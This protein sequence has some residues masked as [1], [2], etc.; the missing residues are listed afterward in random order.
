LTLQPHEGNRQRIDGQTEDTALV[1]MPSD[2]MRDDPHTATVAQMLEDVVVVTSSDTRLHH[3]L[4]PLLRPCQLP[5][6]SSSVMFAATPP[7]EKELWRDRDEKARAV[8]ELEELRQDDGLVTRLLDLSFL[9][10]FQEQIHDDMVGQR[11]VKV[12]MFGEADEE[13]RDYAAS[14]GWRC[15]ARSGAAMCWTTSSSCSPTLPRR[16]GKL[17][18]TLRGVG[19]R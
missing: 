19:V 6:R 14:S 10:C 8:R 7:L 12:L 16:P 9:L 18:P 13:T 1:L 3:L 5:P 17:G 15:R 4:C 2:K 11:S